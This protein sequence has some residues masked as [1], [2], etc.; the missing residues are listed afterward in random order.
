MNKVQKTNNLVEISTDAEHI[1]HRIGS[2]DYTEIRKVMT[3][4]PDDWEEISVADIPPYTKTEY[5]SKVAEL[6]REK[7]TADEEFALQRKMINAVMSSETISEDGA[8]NKAI[9]EYQAYNTYVQG[10]KQKAKD[11]SLYI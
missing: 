3:S 5:D 4:N 10:C 8:A 6:V 7:Y 1:L 9:E 2:E 11:A